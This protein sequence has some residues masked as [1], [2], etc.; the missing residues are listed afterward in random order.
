MF[1]DPYTP[2]DSVY[3]CYDCGTR[4]SESSPGR[5]PECDS[6]VKNLTVPRE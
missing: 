1:T 2:D 6:V 4:I 5:C 3:E